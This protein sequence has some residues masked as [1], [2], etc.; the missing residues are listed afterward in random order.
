MDSDCSWWLLIARRYALN[1]LFG[2][3]I[4]I[5]GI[6]FTVLDILQ[7]SGTALFHS[8]CHENAY[9]FGGHGSPSNAFSCA[10]DTVFYTGE[11]SADSSRFLPIP[12]D[13]S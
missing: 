8:A 4:S 10:N 2:L 9:F 3:T 11:I 5:L 12:P 7:Q 1:I 13:S 6:Y